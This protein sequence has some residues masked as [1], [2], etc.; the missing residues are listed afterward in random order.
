MFDVAPSNLE[1]ARKGLIASTRESRNKTFSSKFTQML[2]FLA[3]KRSSVNLQD[4]CPC[5]DTAR[6]WTHK[7]VY[8]SH[9]A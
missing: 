4:K 9:L 3:Q 1:R 7:F 5:K 8:L 6:T 2:S